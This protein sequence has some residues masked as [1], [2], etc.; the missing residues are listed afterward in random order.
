M[1]AA[2]RAA[3]NEAKPKRFSYRLLPHHEA[4]S[5]DRIGLERRSMIKSAR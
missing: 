3:V 2:A 4:P 1:L 5:T